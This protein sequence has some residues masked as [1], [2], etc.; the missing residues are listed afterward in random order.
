MNTVALKAQQ[1]V[2]TNF[3]LIQDKIHT[4]I[5]ASWKQI[6]KLAWFFEQTPSYSERLLRDKDLGAEFRRMKL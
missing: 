3:N 6:K 1:S 5:E 2:D 4:V